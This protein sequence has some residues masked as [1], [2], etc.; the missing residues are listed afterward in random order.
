MRRV[1]I[2][3]LDGGLATG[4][5]GPVDVFTVVNAMAARRHSAPSLP[6]LEWQIQ[7][8]SGQ[9]I[10]TA[11]GVTIQAHARLDPEAAADVILLPGLFIESVGP[12]LWSEL[13]R[14]RWLLP[15]LRNQLER[16]VVLAANCT[17][18]LLLAEAGVLDGRMATTSWWLSGV[19]RQR[20]PAVD[21]RVDQAVTQDRGV[22][23]S[24]AS[25]AGLQLALRLAERFCGRGVALSAA[26][27]LLLDGSNGSQAPFNSLALVGGEAHG[28]ALVQR[29]QRWIERRIGEPFQ[30]GALAEAL[31]V[32]ER[33]VIRRFKAAL[34][35]TP[36]HHAQLMKVQEAKLLLETGEVSW[37]A[38][39]ERVGYSDASSF[40]R[41]FKREVGLS[42][43]AYQTRFA[44]KRA[45][46]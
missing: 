17:A 40:R 5:A 2:W 28:D 41:L 43:G 30:L 14:H 44:Q 20:Y 19:F 4:V 46:A 42:P 23:C 38:V 31:A 6:A 34:A 37:D 35:V 9:P 24:G 27:T 26:K 16:G 12:A 3:A 15:A 10:R 11:G 33:T 13:Q 36:G 29:A 25:T 1:L 32:S 22:F 21:L 18:T 45:R 7:S 39:C 8:V